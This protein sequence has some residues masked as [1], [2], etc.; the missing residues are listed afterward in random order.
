MKV[1]VS[2]TRLILPQYSSAAALT[3]S[4]KLIN[5]AEIKTEHANLH[6]S[7]INT[8]AALNCIKLVD[9]T[10]KTNCFAVF[11]SKNISRTHQSPYK[12][13]AFLNVLLAFLHFKAD[14]SAHASC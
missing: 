3:T 2:E 9:L 6:D 8:T 4:S 13:G 10:V 14:L 5:L 1:K 7:R 12:K 11:R